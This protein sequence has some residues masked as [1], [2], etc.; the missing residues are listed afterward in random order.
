MAKK[1]V[2]NKADEKPSLEEMKASG[3][4]ISTL[5]D[6]SIRKWHGY[7]RVCTAFI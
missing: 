3:V 7:S 4:D 6:E 1:K 2:T 5:N